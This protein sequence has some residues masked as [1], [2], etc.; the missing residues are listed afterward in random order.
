MGIVNDLTDKLSRLPV[1]YGRHPVTGFGTKHYIELVGT[2]KQVTIQRALGKGPWDSREALYYGGELIDPANSIFHQGLANDAPDAF[3]PSDIAHPN[4]AYEATRLPPG[5]AEEDQPDRAVGI[6]KTLRVADYDAAGVQTGFAYSPSPARH[7][8]DLRLR[9]KRSNVH[10]NWPAWVDWRDMCA[11]TISWDDGA[12]TPHQ[13]SLVAQAGGA[14]APGTYWVRIATIKGADLSS[15]S[16]DRA[17]DGVTTAKVV[18]GGGNLKFQVTWASQA[19]RGATGYR[20]YIGTAEG[21]QDRYFTVAGGSTNTLVVTTLVGA[22]MGAPPNIATGALLRQIPRFESHLFF[23]P[24]FELASALDKI[25]QI[26]CMDW[27]YSGGKLVFLTPEIRE[28]I[29]T[30]NKAESNTFRTWQIDR[31][32]RPNQIIV[33]YRNLDSQFLEPADPPVIVPH[34]GTPAGDPRMVL[35]AKEGI[36]PFEIQGGG[37]YRSQAERVGYYWYRRLVESDQIL[38]AVGSVKTYFVLPGNVINV[39]NDVPN[40]NNVQFLIEEKEEAEDTKAGYPLTARVYG[41]WYSDTDQRPLPSPFPV[42]NPATFG[43]PSQA[44]SVALSEINILQADQTVISI[45]RVAA[46]FAPYIGKQKGRVYYKKSTEAD[47]LYKDAGVID[48]DPVTLQGAMEIRGLEK[49]A[50]DIKVVPENSFVSAGL[51]GAAVHSWT[52]TGKLTAPGPI[53]NLVLSYDGARIVGTF[54]PSTA[55]DIKQYE[56][57]KVTGAQ[58]GIIDHGLTRRFTYRPP[59]NWSGSLVF[60]VYARNWSNVLSTGVQLSISPPTAPQVADVDLTEQVLVEPDQ[61]YNVIIKGVVTF[62]ASVYPQRGR[63]FYKKS[64]EAE[65]L[66]RYWDHHSGRRFESVF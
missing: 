46:E 62:A 4:A 17:D 19:Q 8:I 9:A 30:L 16:K 34:P 44:A 66:Y 27:H 47:A 41:E 23:V 6:Y 15:A 5:M 3:F 60:K 2:Q 51:A 49:V 54:D 58:E 33:N 28:P 22:T 55:G 18:I 48:P 12:L 59:E 29:F 14:L 31:R 57:Y 26:T 25:A 53:S 65:R 50:Y 36:R 40:W 13:V 61:S 20:V 39:T 24:V 43:E 7:A 42:T 10:V 1:S 52:V 11:E 63:V 32:N 35:Q 37:M 38:E 21:A 64:T 45:I 56:M